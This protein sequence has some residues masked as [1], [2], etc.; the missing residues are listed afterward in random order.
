VDANTMARAS[1]RRNT[2]NEGFTSALMY[3]LCSKIHNSNDQSN[4]DN[5]KDASAIVQLLVIWEI[6]ND[7][8]TRVNTIL[9]KHDNTTIWD[10]DRLKTLCTIYHLLDRHNR[11]TEGTWRLDNATV[12]MTT[13]RPKWGHTIEITISEGTIEDDYMEP[14]WASSI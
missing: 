12:L 7:H 5:T 13:L 14:L 2:T 8:W 4:A 6:D 10:E 1:F 11:I 9:I 3:R